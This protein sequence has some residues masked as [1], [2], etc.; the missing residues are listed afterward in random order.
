M[1]FLTIIKCIFVIN[2]IIWFLIII[3]IFFW[4]ILLIFICVK[5]SIQYIGL[6]LTLKSLDDISKFKSYSYFIFFRLDSNFLS[7]WFG[8]KFWSNLVCTFARSSTY[9]SSIW[10]LRSSC[11]YRTYFWI[12]ILFKSWYFCYNCFTWL[13]FLHALYSLLPS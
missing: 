11:C 4:W 1:I 7:G 5:L 2:I 12:Y 10:L 13:N 3:L 8:S 6:F 9:A